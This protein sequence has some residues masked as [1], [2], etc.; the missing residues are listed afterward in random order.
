MAFITTLEADEMAMKALI[1]QHITQLQAISEGMSAMQ[2]RNRDAG[3][4]MSGKRIIRAQSKFNDGLE[5]LRQAEQI[6]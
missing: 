2:T 3:M 4:P 1:R 5:L 6:L